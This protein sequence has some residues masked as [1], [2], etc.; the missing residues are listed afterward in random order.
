LKNCGLA[1]SIRACNYSESL[2]K[3]DLIHFKGVKI[4]QYDAF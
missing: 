1:S 4:V 3:G 2:M